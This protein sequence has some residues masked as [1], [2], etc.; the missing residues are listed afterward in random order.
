MDIGRFLKLWLLCS[1]AAFG[2]A[3]AWAFVPIL[4]FLAL[5]T[6]AFAAVAALVI[7]AARA[8]ERRRRR[9]SSG[10]GD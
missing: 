2:L 8:I 9:R 6:G 4:V 5:V 10:T 3:L 1:L 7:A